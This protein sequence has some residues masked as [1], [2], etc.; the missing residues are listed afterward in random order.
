[1]KEAL[2]ELA[3]CIGS[4]LLQNIIGGVVGTIG[5]LGILECAR[6]WLRSAF[7]ELYE[8]TFVFII[9]SFIFGLILGVFR[10]FQE[11]YKT[12]TSKYQQRK[13]YEESECNRFMRLRY[14]E[15]QIVYEIFVKGSLLYDVEKM[16]LDL[17]GF[18]ID[19]EIPSTFWG[20][21]LNVEIV[22]NSNVRLT[23]NKFSQ[24]LL[25]RRPELLDCCK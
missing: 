22:G 18:L 25:K 21:Y 19:F 23:L 24:K 12:Y 20:H 10:R 11:Y 5:V 3:G 8:F 9:V 17:D 16:G 4:F 13:K 14:H 7:S 6:L 15:K 1:M 2:K